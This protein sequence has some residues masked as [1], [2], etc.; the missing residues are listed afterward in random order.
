M[1]RLATWLL[2]LGLAACSGGTDPLGTTASIRPVPN[3][4]QGFAAWTDTPPTYRFGPGDKIKVQ[5]L[6]TP[7]LGE[8]ALIAPD[9]TIG[10][11]AAGHVQAAGRSAEDLE[12]EVA[13]AS[14]GM[15]THPVVT[16]SLDDP[17]ASAVY[18]GGQVK[19]PGAYPINGRRGALEAVLLAGGFDPEARVDEV[20]LIRRSPTDRPMLRTVNLQD[21]LQTGGGGEVPLFP[22]DI[23][24]VPRNRIS[25]VDLWID[26]FINKFLPFNKAFSYTINRNTPGFG[27]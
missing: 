1:R 9:G 17:A 3:Q 20:V 5:Y 11:R 27:T 2:L 24:F 21:F 10:L 18:V 26:Q 23:V 4:P 14:R 25:E 22:G 16:V 7:E 13:Q 15:L 12:K 6:L 8:D 19:R